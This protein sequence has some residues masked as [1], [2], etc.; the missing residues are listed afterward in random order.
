MG[1]LI[2]SLPEI[3]EFNADKVPT[4]IL[5]LVDNPIHLKNLSIKVSFV[6]WVIFFDYKTFDLSV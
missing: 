5:D 4:P 2:H 1:G 6:S 3:G